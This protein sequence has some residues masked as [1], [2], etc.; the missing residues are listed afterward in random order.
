MPHPEFQARRQHRAATEADRPEPFSPSRTRVTSASDATSPGTASVAVRTAITS[1]FTASVIPS[2][3]PSSTG[4]GPKLTLSQSFG[5]GA[6]SGKDALLSRTTLEGLA[7][8]D[9]GAGQRRLEARFG[10]GFGMFGG[11]FTGTPEIGLGLSDAGRDYSLGWRLTRAGGSLELSI[12]ATR[13]ES[14]NDN[15]PPEHGIGARLTARF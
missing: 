5:A 8:N 14:A 6:A 3:P 12:D 10:Y 11:R 7:A 9:N 4:R 13:R 2:D 15:A 1:D